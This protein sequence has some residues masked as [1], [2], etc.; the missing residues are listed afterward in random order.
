LQNISHVFSPVGL[1]FILFDI[2]FELFKVTLFMRFSL[3]SVFIDELFRAPKFD[4]VFFVCFEQV[5][6]VKVVLFFNLG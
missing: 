4:K 2:A 3:F 6:V 5:S 1:I